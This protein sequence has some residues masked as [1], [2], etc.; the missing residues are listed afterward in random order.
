[1]KLTLENL[2]AFCIDDDGCL[3]WDRG[4]NSLGYPQA[5]LGDKPGQMV[6]RHIFIDLLGNELKPGQRISARCNKRLCVAPGCLMAR[7]ASAIL[8]KAY[9]SGRRSTERE[10]AARHRLGVLMSGSTMTWEIADQIRR[11]PAHLAHTEVARKYGLSATAVSKIRRGVSW[12]RPKL[13]VRSV[14]ELAAA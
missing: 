6:R 5:R 9:R 1:M 10:Y 8:R 2:P 4:V 11:E 12:R 3:L 13:P 14:F 7:S